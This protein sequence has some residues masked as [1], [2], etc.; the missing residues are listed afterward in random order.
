MFDRDLGEAKAL[1]ATGEFQ[2]GFQICRVGIEPRAQALDPVVALAR[3]NRVE[4]LTLHRR[5]LH[6]PGQGFGNKHL[7]MTAP[8]Y[9]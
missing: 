2:P 1:V 4:N 8:T 5:K 3:V 6:R 9:Q 7:L